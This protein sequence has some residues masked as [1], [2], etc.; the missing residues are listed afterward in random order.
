MIDSWWVGLNPV[1]GSGVASMCTNRSRVNFYAAST[2]NCVYEY[3]MCEPGIE[4]GIHVFDLE[5]GEL[6]LEIA[7][8][9]SF[10]ISA[11]AHPA[12][13]LDQIVV[14]GEDGRMRLIV[15]CLLPGGIHT[16]P[17]LCLL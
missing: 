11:I 10:K 4:D 12:S 16:I 17:L 7:S 3:S 1:V 9:E 6:V 15:S 13:Y 8:P 5:N 14:G 2:D